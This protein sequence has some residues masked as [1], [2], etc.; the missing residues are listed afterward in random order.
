MATPQKSTQALKSGQTIKV[1]PRMGTQLTAVS[2]QWFNRPDDQ[3]FLSL[4]DLFQ[5]VMARSGEAKVALAD[6]AMIKVRAEKGDEDLMSF[7]YEGVSV[8]PNHWSFGQVASL[9]GAPA[10]YLRKLPAQIA[11]INM[12][13]GLSK[14]REENVKLYY[15]N[16]RRELMAATGPEYGR[17][18]DSE[19]V[20][21]IQ[22]VAGNGT[23]DTR[24]KIPGVLD[25]KNYHY[26]PFVNPTK[27]STTLYASDRDVFIFL[28][29]DT[30]PI[31]IGKLPGGD[32]D[33]VFRG[34]YMWNS[35]V[36]SKSLG[37]STFLFRAVCQN[38][39]IWG[40]QDIEQVTMRHS[41]NAPARF[42]DEIK[43][44]L[45]DYVDASDKGVIT[46]IRQAQAALVAKSDDEAM[47]FLDRKGF[48]AALAKRVI[49]TVMVEED[50]RPESIWDFVNGIT[51]VARTIGHTDERVAMER[52]AGKML[53]S[54][55]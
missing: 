11:G 50:H 40:V 17:I 29:D 4:T 49:E 6:P 12:Q 1:D 44:A 19:V 24:W 34:F 48:T 54:A 39:C 3:R 47:A 18:K 43:P 51:A 30:H 35:E 2:S 37:L 31:E 52:L 27:Q 15:H 28:V 55:K 10:G 45:I 42:V 36:G 53:A 46:G 22:H 7:D 26:N 41:K 25:W 5:S 20:A 33:V 16:G 23:G 32:P 14:Y 13:W 38:R 9:V 21:A 8:R